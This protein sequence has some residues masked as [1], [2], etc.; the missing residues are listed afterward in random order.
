ML[1]T[2]FHYLGRLNNSKFFAGI[3]LIPQSGDKDYPQAPFT[4][5]YTSKEIA[6]EYGDASLWCSG[7]IELGLNAFDNN[8]WAA[9]DYMTLEQA[10]DQDTDDKKLF[11]IKMQRFAK[12]YFEGDLKRLTYCM[13]DV[14]NWKRYTDLFNSFN[15]V[16]YTQ[17]L[18]T[19]DN[20][21]GIE[22]ISC[23]GGACLI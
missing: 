17:L 18:E 21:T 19:E 3:S 5:V 16:D 12:K 2:V 4:T 9:C 10:S 6:K 8:L 23:A 22:E 1:S 14:Y 7:L 11:A 15:K 20:T 13:K